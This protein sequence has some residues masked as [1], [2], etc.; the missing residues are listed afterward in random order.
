MLVEEALTLLFEKN[1]N[2]SWYD[3]PLLSF[4]VCFLNFK[5]INFLFSIRIKIVMVR[6]NDSN[7]P[8]F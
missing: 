1:S 6:S 8:F 4:V 2:I 3:L 5:K 7:C